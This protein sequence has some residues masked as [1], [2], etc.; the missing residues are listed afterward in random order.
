MIEGKWRPLEPGMVLTIEPGIYIPED[1]TAVDAKYRKL[2]IRIEDTVY[3]TE[4]GCEVLTAD[5]PK[6]IE[7]IE[8]L[9]NQKSASPGSNMEITV[10]LD[11]LRQ[12]L[13]PL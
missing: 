10:A 7:A 12:A 3:V 9:M 8:T 4:Q 1:M 2:G 11:A 6:T 5:A 13:S